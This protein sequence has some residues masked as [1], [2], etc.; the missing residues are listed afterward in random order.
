M[1]CCIELVPMY[2]NLC[3][4]SFCESL[5]RASFEKWVKEWRNHWSEDQSEFLYLPKYNYQ[6][7]N[8]SLHLSR[9]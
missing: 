3:K 6:S 4:I 5:Y 7:I 8:L 1:I 2:M 9:P